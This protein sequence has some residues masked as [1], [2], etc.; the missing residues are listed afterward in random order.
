M[1]WN[2]RSAHLKEKKRR[3]LLFFFF[4]RRSF[5]VS[6]RNRCWLLS[7]RRLQ[8]NFNLFCFSSPGTYTTSRHHLI[9]ARNLGRCFNSPWQKS[10]K[11]SKHD[12]TKSCK[13]RFLFFFFCKKNIARCY[14]C[15]SMRICTTWSSLRS[16]WSKNRP[17]TTQGTGR[18]VANGSGNG[19]D[20][21]FAKLKSEWQM[22]MENASSFHFFFR[23]AFWKFHL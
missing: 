6:G 2:V 16:S 18:R 10:H 19:L 17:G 11:N 21:Q 12:T 1:A 23:F 14:H 5:N 15:C 9:C 8:L 22:Y 4:S 7:C 20:T 3:T 13:Q